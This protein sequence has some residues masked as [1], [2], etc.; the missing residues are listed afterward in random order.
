MTLAICHLFERPAERPLVADWIYQ[1]FWTHR[2]GYSP[3]HFEALLAD[4]TDPDHIPLSLLALA[5]NEPVGTV[6]LIVND[7]SKRP[8][9]T[10]WLAALFVAP[11][12]RGQ[13]VGS[14]LV[15]RLCEEAARLGY[16]RLYLGTDIP[17][18]YEALSARIHEQLDDGLW[19]LVRELDATAAG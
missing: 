7:N 6:N 9:L 15:R 8:Q 17:G 1:A 14:A 11:A 5:E 2:P 13:G 12:F 19:V 4:A 18:F 3:A 16:R 10:P